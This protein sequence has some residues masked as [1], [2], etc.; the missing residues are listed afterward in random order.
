V[1]EPA[2]IRGEI[3]HSAQSL[4]ARYQGR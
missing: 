1:V 3:L 2:T 4:L